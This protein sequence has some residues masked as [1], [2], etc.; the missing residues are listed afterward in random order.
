[1]PSFPAS[2]EILDRLRAD[3]ERTG[4]T[5]VEILIVVMII[6]ILLTVAVPNFAAA[7][8]K[9]RAR[10]CVKNLW[11]IHQAKDQYAMDNKTAPTDPGPALNVLCGP[12]NYIKQIVTCPSGGAYAV[13]DFSTDPTCSIGATAPL[14]HAL[15]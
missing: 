8:E 2:R 14:P 15:P 5:L 12:G 6:G 13:N 11:S 3:R 7:R 9:A 10:L 1:M 4:F